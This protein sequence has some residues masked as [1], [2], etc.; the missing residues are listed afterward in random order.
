LEQL[1]LDEG[2][3][4]A[5]RLQTSA[6]ALLLREAFIAAKRTVPRAATN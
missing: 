4:A 1:L 3:L 6:Q 2:S 5:A